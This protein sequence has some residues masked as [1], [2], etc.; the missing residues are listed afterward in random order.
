MYVANQNR[1]EGTAPAKI[2]F[3]APFLLHIKRCAVS[4]GS[5]QKVISRFTRTLTQFGNLQINKQI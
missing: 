2:M 4:Q 3:Q 5:T 1:V